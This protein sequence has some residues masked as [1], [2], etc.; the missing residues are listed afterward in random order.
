[1]ST[2]SETV[3]EYAVR[4]TQINWRVVGSGLLLQGLFAVFILRFKL[5]F[6]V[7]NWMGL[8]VNEFMSYSEAGARFVFGDG[9]KEHMVVFSVRPDLQRT[10]YDKLL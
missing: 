4:Y 8:R 3:F 7:L 9:Y 5:G 2:T 6:Q 10:V 1:M